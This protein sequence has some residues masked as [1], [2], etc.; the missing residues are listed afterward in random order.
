[1]L[2]TNNLPTSNLAASPE[3]THP[4][5]VQSVCCMGYLALHSDTRCVTCRR[6]A[7]A[8]YTVHGLSACISKQVMLRKVYT[9]RESRELETLRFLAVIVSAILSGTVGNLWHHALLK[10]NSLR[11]EINGYYFSISSSLHIMQLL[12]QLQ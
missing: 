5:D 9:Q 6:N 2:S 12:I 11:Q 8:V 4:L 3:G 1:M 7:L 10:C